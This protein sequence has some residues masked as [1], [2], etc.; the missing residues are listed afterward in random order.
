MKHKSVL[1]WAGFKWLRIRSTSLLFRTWQ[2]N[3]VF[4]TVRNILKIWATV[5]SQEAH[6]WTSLEALLHC[7]YVISG[8]IV[9]K[10]T[11]LTAI[12]RILHYVTRLL[13]PN[14]TTRQAHVSQHSN[15]RVCTVTSAVKSLLYMEFSP[16]VQAT[17]K[18][19]VIQTR[20]R[21][22]HDDVADIKK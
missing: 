10:R 5:I 9:C 19:R 8:R 11:C 21:R 1:L 15:S 13:S 12:L 4:H 3:S 14:V 16:S 2:C 17:S 22:T 18:G 20:K 6:C 7:I